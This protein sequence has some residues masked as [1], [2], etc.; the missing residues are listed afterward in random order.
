MRTRGDARR[1]NVVAV[2]MHGGWAPLRPGPRRS[3][4]PPRPRAGPACQD[5]EQTR[6]NMHPAVATGPRAAV[7]RCGR[8]G[9]PARG[10]EAWRR[11][12]GER[13]NERDDEGTSEWAQEGATGIAQPR[14]STWCCH[15]RWH[16]TPS[17]RSSGARGCSSPPTPMQL[18]EPFKAPFTN[19]N[20]ELK[21][22]RK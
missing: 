7:H 9:K 2:S 19:F 18:M 5:Q 4:F 10:A 14:I 12:A 13:D 3:P 1:A 17:L 8:W 16:P 20:H 21:E 15:L 6:E 11:G 22:G